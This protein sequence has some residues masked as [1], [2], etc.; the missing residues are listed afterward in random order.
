MN[1]KFKGYQKKDRKIHR[2]TYFRPG[3][4]V[5]L[6]NSSADPFRYRRVK[7][8]KRFIKFVDG[9][10]CLTILYECFGYSGYGCK[11]VECIHREEQTL[12]ERY[13]DRLCWK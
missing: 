11:K 13:G 12:M 10:T 7:S 3:M 5:R 4:G 2:G 9:V 8:A 6:L 1:V